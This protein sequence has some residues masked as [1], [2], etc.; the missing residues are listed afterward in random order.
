MDLTW[1]NSRH[2]DYTVIFSYLKTYSL[3]SYIKLKLRVNNL[4]LNTYFLIRMYGFLYIFYIQVFIASFRESEKSSNIWVYNNALYLIHS[5]IKSKLMASKLNVNNGA[6]Y[7]QQYPVFVI[8]NYFP[9][10]TWSNIMVLKT[11][12]IPSLQA[13]LWLY[14]N[15]FWDE[16]AL[17]ML[18]KTFLKSNYCLAPPKIEGFC[19]F[20]SMIQ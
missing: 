13:M 4:I 16:Q 20:Q 1:G 8:F 11:V 2:S 7:Q 10:N 18:I 3:N 14:Y 12:G 15:A 17:L 5:Y 6:L 9:N 19:C